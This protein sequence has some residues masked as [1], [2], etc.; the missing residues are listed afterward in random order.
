[1]LL[2]LVQAIN[3]LD[4]LNLSFRLSESGAPLVAL[5]SID[6]WTVICSWVNN[7]VLLRKDILLNIKIGR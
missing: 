4:R 3:I 2:I 6:P 5:S 7:D 1:M